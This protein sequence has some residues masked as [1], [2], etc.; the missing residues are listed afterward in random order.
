M[1]HLAPSTS[2]QSTKIVVQGL[3]VS[4][5]S[6][7]RGDRAE[8]IDSDKAVAV[9]ITCITP[10]IDRAELDD[11]SFSVNSG[12]SPETFGFPGLT[13]LAGG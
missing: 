11:D 12:R 3:P 1:S 6:E 4:K 8:L 13:S 9:L 2:P 5:C 7:P 10:R